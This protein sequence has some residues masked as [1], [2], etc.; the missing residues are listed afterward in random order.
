MSMLR[1]KLDPWISTDIIIR[2]DDLIVEDQ[3]RSQVS[4]YEICGGQSGLKV[5]VFSE[6][7]SFTLSASL[8][9]RSINYFIQIRSSQTFLCHGPLRK[10]GVTYGP[11]LRK[12]YL[13]T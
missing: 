6:Y 13:N 2:V 10:S 5:M 9:E 11:L 12:M 7:F 4:Q 8:Q 3:V 1:N